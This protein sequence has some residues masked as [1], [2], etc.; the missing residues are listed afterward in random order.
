MEKPQRGRGPAQS[1][2]HV[3]D[4][5]EAPAGAPVLKLEQAL[6]AAENPR[7][8]TCTICRAATELDAAARVRTRCRLKGA[9]DGRRVHEARPL[10]HGG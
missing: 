9:D 7:V 8:R 2:L 5:P 4:C 10:R 1:V 3:F 6:N